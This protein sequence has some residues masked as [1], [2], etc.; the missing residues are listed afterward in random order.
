MLSSLTL[1][2]FQGALYGMLAVGLVLV[3]K[4]VR[5]FNF[6][7]GEFGTV[8]VFAAYGLF[9]GLNLPYGVAF[10]GGLVA[11]VLL[12]LIMERAVI[13]PLFE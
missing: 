7:Q 5:V 4:G 9:E 3:Y 11:A 13:R 1:G 6:A 10:L 2:I 12:G 8:A